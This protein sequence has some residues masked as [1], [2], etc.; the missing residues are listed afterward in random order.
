MPYMLKN[1]YPALRNAGY[2]QVYYDIDRTASV[3]TAVRTS[4]AAPRGLTRTV[5]KTSGLRG[6]AGLCGTWSK[7]TTKPL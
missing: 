6:S 2:L 5:L 3:A 1:F 4:T 7:E